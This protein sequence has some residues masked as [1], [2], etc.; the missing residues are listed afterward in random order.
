MKFGPKFIISILIGALCLNLVGCS[1]FASTIPDMTEQEQGMVVE[2]ATK[3]LLK[4]DKKK[5]DKVGEAPSETVDSSDTEAS[6]ENGGN[7]FPNENDDSTSGTADSSDTLNTADSL[8]SDDGVDPSN[9]E[10][11]DNTGSGASSFGTIHEALG[12]GGTVDISY[13]GCEVK[14]FYPDSTD[15]YFVMTA[16]SG[17]KFLVLKFKI[18]NPNS[19]T[20]SVDIA[21]LNS[22]FKIILNDKKKNALTT[23]L[24]N[25]M[26]FFKSDVDAGAEEEVVLV[27]EYPEN[28]LQNIGSLKLSVSNSVGDSDI[29]LQ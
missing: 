7:V 23:L 17:C 9:V 11:I 18:K 27:G 24:L 22:R 13:E 2:Y 26:A 16:T 6:S 12:L 29:N 25:D 28:E 8:N 20:A 10:V 3:S 1:L 15:S 14:D 4:Y 21:A 19:S 5:G